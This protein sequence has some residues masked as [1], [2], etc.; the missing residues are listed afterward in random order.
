MNSY[1]CLQIPTPIMRELLNYLYS[2]CSPLEPPE[3][4]ALALR[5]WLDDM[6]TKAL[7]EADQAPDGYLWKNV[8]LPNGT[9]I[10][11][12][13]K[14][15]FGCAFISKGEFIY[16]GEA[17][18]PNQFA[19]LAGE[20][21]RNAW[22]DLVVRIPGEVRPKRAYILRR[23]QAGQLRKPVAPPAAVKDPLE[24]PKDADLLPPPH[25]PPKLNFGEIPDWVM[26]NRR[27]NCKCLGDTMFED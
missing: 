9:R 14:S 26:N 17:I 10:H 20:N 18:S 16:R 12:S 11:F 15:E 21:T 19:A 6:R 13:G 23:E 1:T 22:R 3:A 24:R 8:F 5:F 7:M 25:K 27:K 4:A 2:A